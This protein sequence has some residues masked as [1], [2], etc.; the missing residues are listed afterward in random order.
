MLVSVGN[1]RTPFS[2]TKNA[3]IKGT[4]TDAQKAVLDKRYLAS[5]LLNKNQKLDTYAATGTGATGT[6]DYQTFIGESK[7]FT[8]NLVRISDSWYI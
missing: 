7:I 1:S 5:Q 6:I 8:I 2:T 4:C 3:F